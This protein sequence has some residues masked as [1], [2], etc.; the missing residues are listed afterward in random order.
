[1]GPCLELDLG[2]RTAASVAATS[3]TFLR[4]LLSATLCDP[5]IEN[6]V[7]CG[8]RGESL[9]KIVIQVGVVAGDNEQGSSQFAPPV[10]GTAIT[11]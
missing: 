11:S 4:D 8:V 6:H 7:D 2:F 5:S 3:L 9:A 1:M 10:W